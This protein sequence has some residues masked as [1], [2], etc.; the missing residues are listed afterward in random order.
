[1]NLAIFDDKPELFY[2]L[3]MTRAVCDLRC[4]IL[5]LRQ[6]LQALLFGEEDTVIIDDDLT[7]LYHVRH[8]EWLI[9]S[10]KGDTLFVNSRVKVTPESLKEL[11]DLRQNQGLKDHSGQIIAFRKTVNQTSMLISDL[12]SQ[13]EN[14]EMP[15]TSVSL[16]ANLADLIMDNARLIEFDFE[17]FFHDTDNYIETEPGVTILNPYQ[18]WIG[19]GTVLKPGVVID[20]SHG[21]VVIDERAEV[22]SNA[23][24]I[25]PVYL[26]KKSIIKVGA[27]IYGGT[28][29]GPVC[30]I[31]GEVEN[32]II[33]AYSNKQHD[34][35]LGHAYLGEW[36]N[37]GAGTCNSDLKNNYKP[38]AFYSYANKAKVQ[39]DYQFLGAIIG[40]HVKTGINCSLNTGAVIG[41]GCNLWGKDLI[42]DYIPAFSWGEG[43]K[44]IPYELEAFLETAQSVKQRRNLSLSIPEIALFRKL[45]G[46]WYQER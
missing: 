23:V 16:Y 14:L 15:K 25:G 10:V 27:K 41:P 36:V 37:I 3:S 20:A 45:R 43:N 7:E 1:M 26:G 12:L 30:K 22:L 18:V 17:Q 38:V 40:D 44:L 24:I 8:P 4:G 34:G 9:N 32:T 13:F 21:P 46:K 19:E 31:G 6:R 35:F 28:S 33:Q 5:K 2:P 11:K 39:T 29:I 42:S